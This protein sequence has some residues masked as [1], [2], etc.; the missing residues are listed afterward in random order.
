MNECDY[1]SSL[2]EQYDNEILQLS[3]EDFEQLEIEYEQ[4]V[5][6]ETLDEIYRKL[7]EWDEDKHLYDFWR[8]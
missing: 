1:Y 5:S 2:E 7:Q 4:E 8:I 3:D 6:D